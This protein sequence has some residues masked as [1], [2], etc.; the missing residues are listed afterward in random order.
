MLAGLALFTSCAATGS[1]P[2]SAY[3]PPT[4]V[5]SSVT[6]AAPAMAPELEFDLLER[7]QTAPALLRRAFLALELRRPQDALDEAGEVLY[8]PT[9]PSSN[10]EAFARFLRAEAY[11]QLGMPER[12][13]YDRE[14]A[15]AL[16]L[17]LQLRQRLQ[18]VLPSAPE[19]PRAIADVDLVVANRSAWHA[20][21]PRRKNMDAMGAI[22]RLTIHHSAMFLR[23]TRPSACAAQIQ[24]IQIDHMETRGYGDIG[25]HYLID[26][27]GRIWAG[28][29]L[30]WQ[31]AHA[32]GDHNI[33]N[34]GVCLLGNF[35]PGR[36][37][38]KPSPQQVTAMERLIAKLLRRHRLGADDIFCHSHFKNTECPGELMEPV[39]S[40]LIRDLQRKG[41]SGIAAAAAEH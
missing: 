5:A 16:T 24:R 22:S 33:G 21:S 6:L 11:V 28:R 12:G 41:G 14:R 36:K 32:S 38:H 10:E 15:A 13:E 19:Q 1:K 4:T 30:Q 25:Y 27:S 23:D 2:I 17:D 39:V 35:M 20:K 7:T 26:P 29:D 37:G 8:G 31:G 3:T 34:I 18:A 40:Q 9:K